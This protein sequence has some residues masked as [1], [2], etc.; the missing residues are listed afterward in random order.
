MTMIIQRYFCFI[1]GYWGFNSEICE[2]EYLLRYIDSIQA[3]IKKY[4]PP[5][6]LGCYIGTWPESEKIFEIHCNAEIF[7][8][9]IF[10]CFTVKLT[11]PL[12]VTGEK[13]LFNAIEGYMFSGLGEMI[14]GD[15]IFTEKGEL[16]IGLWDSPNHYRLYTENDFYKLIIRRNQK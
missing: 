9:N 1:N 12:S 8:K 10:G 11:S 6:G 15:S 3:L 7:E 2:K 4:E 16:S 5:A 14:E 13:L